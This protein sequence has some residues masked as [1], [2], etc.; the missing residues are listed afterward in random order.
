MVTLAEALF[1]SES[2]I[3][4]EIG[5]HECLANGSFIVRFTLIARESYSF[6]QG[7]SCANTKD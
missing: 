6:L 3:A 7:Y 5:A 2:S 1:T 4:T